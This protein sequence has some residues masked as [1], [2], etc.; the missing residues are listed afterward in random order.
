MTQPDQPGPEDCI[1]ILGRERDEHGNRI[2]VEIDP[3]CTWH[4]NGGE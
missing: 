1:C 3:D 2:P 4:L